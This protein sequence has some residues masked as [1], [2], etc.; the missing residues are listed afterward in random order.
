MILPGY[1]RQFR[2]TV[3]LRSI[4]FRSVSF[5]FSRNDRSAKREVSRN[6]FREKTKIVSL[7]L[8]EIMRNEILLE[9]LMS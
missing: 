3:P 8:S 6:L 5:R 4:S 1:F 9:T 7:P 2:Q